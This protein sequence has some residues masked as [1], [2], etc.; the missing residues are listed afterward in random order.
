MADSAGAAGARVR[1]V[2]AALFDPEPRGPAG[3]GRRVLIAQRPPGKHMAGRW[4]FPGGKVGAGETDFEALRRELREELGIEAIRARHC[5]T[6]SHTYPDRTFELSMW[7]VDQFLGEPSALYLHQIKWVAIG[8]LGVEDI[9]EA[10][11]PF[12]EALQAQETQQAD[13]A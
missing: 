7:M 2:A 5:L 3:A 9:L 12:V 13:G 11:R 6:L 10:D 8:Q 1:V 4:E